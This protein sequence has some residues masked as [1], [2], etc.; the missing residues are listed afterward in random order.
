MKKRIFNN[1]P[2]ENSKGQYIF[3]NDLETEY[4]GSNSIPNYVNDKFSNKDLYTTVMGDEINKNIIE[5]KLQYP[6]FNF[7]SF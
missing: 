7:L 4:S 2:T 6:G 1:K 5:Y 3:F